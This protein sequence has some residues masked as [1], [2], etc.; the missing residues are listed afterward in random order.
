M[1]RP[2]EITFRDLDASDFVRK[3]VEE[4]V[5]RLE[6]FHP[7]I[8]GCRVVIEAPHRSAEG[9][10]PPLGISVEVDIPDRPR[11]VAKDAEPQRSIKGDHLSAINRAFE[12]V[13]RQLE[14]LGDKQRREVKRHENARQTGSV[15]QLF[16]EQSYGFIEIGGGPELYFTRNAMVDGDFDQLKVGM[17][18]QVTQATG[19]GPMGPQASSVA[20]MGGQRRG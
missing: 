17:M 19:E 2:L 1:Q 6:R 11:I 13:E 20:I 9:H 7:R 18:V 3:V 8:I 15:V 10:N 14:E 16:P 12:A 5:G 4:R